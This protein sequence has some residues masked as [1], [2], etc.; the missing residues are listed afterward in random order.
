M[1]EDVGGIVARVRWAMPRN[2]DVMAVCDGYEA[3]IA[4]N[5]AR[6][7]EP[8]AKVVKSATKSDVTVPCPICEKKRAV[9][10]AALRRYRARRKNAGKRIK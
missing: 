10:A 2:A 9:K 6:G 1:V 8:T 4:A 5:Y 7:F 3:A